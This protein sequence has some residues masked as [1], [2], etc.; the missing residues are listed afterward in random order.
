MTRPLTG[1]FD[2]VLDLFDAV[3]AVAPDADAFVQPV[4]GDH[5]RRL[6][7]AEWAARAD[8][9]AGWLIDDCGVQPGDV[10]AIQLPSGIDYAIAYQGILRAGAVASGINPRLG[11]GEVSHILDRSAPRLVIDS[12]V[13]DTSLTS[14]APGD[15]LRRRVAVDGLDP[16]A[17]VWTGGTTGYPKGAWF[18]H[19]C[20]RAMAEGAAPL[21]EVGDRRLSPLPFAHVGYMTRVWDELMHLI[22]T[23]VVPSPWTAE[24]A[25][26][27]IDAEK[28]TVCQG[29]PTQY[30]MMFDH[31]AFATTDVSSLRIA[32]IG[33]A[34]IPPE[35]VTEMRERLGCPVVV[36]YA[37]TESCVA[38]GTRLT[39][40]VDT[41]CTTVGRP[42]GGVEMRILDEEAGEEVDTGEVGTVCLRGRATM[43]GYWREPERTAE[44]ID[45]CG[46]LHTGDLGW[47]GED[48]NLRLVGRRTEM[49]IRGGY[50]VYPIEIENALGGFPGIA[51][52]A[53]LGAP[54]EDRLGEIGVLFAVPAPGA[55][56]DLA[57]IRAHVKIELADYKAPDV[58]IEVDE[59]PLTSIGKVDKKM[60]QP[61]AN[62]EAQ[63]W[64]RA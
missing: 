49:Y 12:A 22:T 43:R 59:L 18:D 21:S 54:V 19:H 10:V 44:T 26:S 7:F 32:G 57:A 56:L 61:R 17:I 20:L 8:A 35:L 55:T 52:T 33:A 5:T 31:P 13:V 9:V 62:E 24:A 41:I 37:S 51:A 47:V 11:S 64:R 39:D 6:T 29:V 4:A 53:V 45:G 38:T 2:T 50:N 42:N 48:G 34:R 28:V 36:R 40:D 15:P 63:S 14:L 27:L 30:R 25:L 23:V 16:V 3:L 58:L 1:P 46:W 60:L